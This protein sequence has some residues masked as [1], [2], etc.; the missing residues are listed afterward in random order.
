MAETKAEQKV[1]LEERIGP[2]LEDAVDASEIETPA[3]EI[4]LRRIKVALS[5][6]EKQQ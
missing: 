6:E 3:P 1:L 2:L 4:A 5:A